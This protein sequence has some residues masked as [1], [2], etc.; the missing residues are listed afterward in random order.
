MAN[1]TIRKIC[2]NEPAVRIILLHQFGANSGDLAAQKPCSINQV[3]PMPQQIVGLPVSFWIALRPLRFGALDDQWLYIC[4]LHISRSRVAIP[5]F[6]RKS[7][8]HLLVN[9]AT[10]KRYT[11]IKSFHEAVFRAFWQLSKWAAWEIIPQPS[12]PI[13]TGSGVFFMNFRIMVDFARVCQPRHIDII[14][15]DSANEDLRRICR[16]HEIK[17]EEASI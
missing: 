17:L 15:T 2:R 14:V 9:E 13:L 1:A 4:G 8:S 16:D 3:T 11:G 5:G 6:D 7:G 12:T 10:R